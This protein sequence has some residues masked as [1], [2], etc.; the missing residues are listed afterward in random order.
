[1]A[2]CA[3][4][5]EGTPAGSLPDELAQRDILNG[6]SVDRD[7]EMLV[8]HADLVLVP[9]PRLAHGR[10]RRSLVSEHGAVLPPRF[11]ACGTRVGIVVED[12]PERGV[13]SAPAGLRRI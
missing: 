5:I 11:P 6:G 7:S 10:P 3:G 1:S 12:Y 8:L 9:R 2:S 4:E 13:G